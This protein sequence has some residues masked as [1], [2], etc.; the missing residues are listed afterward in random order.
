M[1]QVK[2]LNTQRSLKTVS[3]QNS[4]SVPLNSPTVAL[5]ET[6]NSQALDN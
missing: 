4:T 3:I 2:K 1:F 6:I 5:E